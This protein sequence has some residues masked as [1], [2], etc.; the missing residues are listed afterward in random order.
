M[1]QNQ[2]KTLTIVRILGFFGVIPFAAFTIMIGLSGKESSEQLLFGLLSYSA[3]ILSFLG[4]AIW[5]QTI[6]CVHWN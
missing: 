5:G 4:G 3:V 6:G 2:K 1:K